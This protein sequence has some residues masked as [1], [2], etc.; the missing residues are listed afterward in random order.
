MIMKRTDF[1]KTLA[2]GV[3]TSLVSLNNGYSYDLLKGKSDSFPDAFKGKKY[4]SLKHEIDN[5]AIW[6][7]WVKGEDIYHGNTD[8]KIS[9]K[10]FTFT[11]QVKEQT[12]PFLIIENKDGFVQITKQCEWQRKEDDFAPMIQR[13][14]VFDFNPSGFYPTVGHWIDIEVRDVLFYKN[15]LVFTKV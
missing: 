9:N 5:S 15:N 7:A 13:R 4:L 6:N 11:Q 2:V 12:L 3:G 10:I 14:G 1:I 8:V